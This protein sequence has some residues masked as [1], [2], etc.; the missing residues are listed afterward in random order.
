MLNRCMNLIKRI[1]RAAKFEQQST[2]KF[3]THAIMQ[4]IRCSEEEMIFS[5][6]GEVVIDDKANL[7]ADFSLN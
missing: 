4:S 1:Q 5:P 2:R 7:P 6:S 3:L